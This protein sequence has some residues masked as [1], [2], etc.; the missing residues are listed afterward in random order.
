MQATYALR[1]RIP[2]FARMFLLQPQQQMTPRFA[3][4]LN[5]PREADKL[6][7]ARVA[8]R[9]CKGSGDSVLSAGC[10]GT[11]GNAAALDAALNNVCEEGD[12]RGAGRVRRLQGEQSNWNSHGVSVLGRGAGCAGCCDS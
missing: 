8:A 4:L 9:F 7:L 11:S 1:K 10:G 3:L 12:L 5:F 2:E 6:K